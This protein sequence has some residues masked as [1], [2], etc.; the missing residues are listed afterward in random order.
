MLAGRWTRFGNQSVCSVCILV[1][2]E[3]W[4][5]ITL[6]N[7][8]FSTIQAGAR[9]TQMRSLF[10]IDPIIFPS[11][12]KLGEYNLPPSILTLRYTNCVKFNFG[13]SH[14]PS[15]SHT[16]TAISDRSTYPSRW[17]RKPI[18]PLQKLLP[19]NYSFVRIQ[20]TLT[21]L[22]WDNSTKKRII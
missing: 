15:D 21:N 6:D 7:F 18:D 11:A 17:R 20:N 13:K 16:N 10:T 5:Q 9:D 1:Y 22:V 19:L 8:A 12:C 3:I 4:W 2:R 14:L